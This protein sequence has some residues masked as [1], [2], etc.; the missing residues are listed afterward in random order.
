M[1]KIISASL[2]LLSVSAFAQTYSASAFVQRDKSF[3]VIL[4]NLHHLYG[5]GRLSVDAKAFAGVAAEGPKAVAGLAEVATYDLGKGWQLL[6]G[7]G[8]AQTSFRINDVNANTIG[9]ILGVSGPID[10]SGLFG[11][12]STVSAPQSAKKAHIISGPLTAG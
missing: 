6:T 12:G 2:A 10:L 8:I 1:K 11:G 7:I 9:L 4:A 3:G 5:I